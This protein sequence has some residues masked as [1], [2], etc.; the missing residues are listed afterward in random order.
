[1]SET[2]QTL[3]PRLE[4]LGITK[5]YPGVVANNNVSLKVMPGEIHALLGENGAGKSTLVKF[6][7]GVQK[8]DSGSMLWEGEEVRLANPNA[9]R[10]L[11]VGMVFQ[12][13]SLFDAMTVEEN[14]SL[15]ISPE[16][17][18]GNLSVR[19]REIS[20]QYGLPLDPDRYVHT[21]SVGERQRIEVVRCLLQDPTLLIM[22]EPT[23]VLTPQEVEELFKT[24]RRLSEE[25]VSIL[26]ISHKLEEIKTLCHTAT[27]MRMG[28]VVAECTPEN[29]TARSMA[30]MMM[31][32]NL[33][34]PER[35]DRQTDGSVRLEV[36]DLDAASTHQHGTDLRAVN[37]QVRAGEV[38]GVAGIAGNGQRELM[39]VLTGEVLVD[40]AESITID[41]TP[42][43]QLGPV[44][45]R[46]IGIGVGLVPEERL[47]HGA[48]P[49]MSLWENGFLSAATRMELIN[50]GFIQV[51]ASSAFAEEVVEQ[52]RVK[53][54]GVTHPAN[55]LSG[56]NLQ[57]FIVGRELV[58]KPGVI[59]VLQPTWGVDA[60]STASI[61]QALIDM[62]TEGAAVLAISQDLEEL[63]EISNRIAVICEGRMSDAQP[64][65]NVTVEEIGLLMAGVGPDG[66]KAHAD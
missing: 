64:A 53:T 10:K 32:E 63:F 31:G 54:P 57:K 44:Q 48:V 61:R 17:T 1:M 50:N 19:I 43:G 25:G 13:F 51:G 66:E 9:A 59:V 62:A 4:L 60:G 26:Y 56:G 30:E 28:E 20:A 29:E 15:G 58:Q 12:H 16:L 52:F 23:S 40:R 49:D 11:G 14:I 7:Y 38:L 8:A 34:S 18:K 27:I 46:G 21:L 2:P 47:G 5:A 42:V 41:G 6:I 36:K 33:V 55:S 35:T 3:T 45:R 65:E 22:D 39:E 37:L 24:L